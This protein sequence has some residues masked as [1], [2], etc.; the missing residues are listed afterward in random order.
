MTNDRLDT[1]HLLQRLLLNRMGIAVVGDKIYWSD[2]HQEARV[3]T[4]SHGVW[5][6]ARF[7]CDGEW[8]TAC[9]PIMVCRS[10]GNESLY[11]YDVEDAAQYSAV[12]ATGALCTCHQAQPRSVTPNLLVIMLC[13]I[14]AIVSSVLFSKS[15]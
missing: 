12:L 4:G 13:C 9:G 2:E 11:R 5:Y 15:R 10:C 14:T 1:M 6:A 3:D 7:A 8:Y